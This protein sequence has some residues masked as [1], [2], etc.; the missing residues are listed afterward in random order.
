MATQRQIDQL[1]ATADLVG[2]V[3]GAIAAMERNLGQVEDEAARLRSAIVTARSMLS[4]AQVVRDA[5]AAA[6]KAD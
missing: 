5:A 4:R 1:S 6:C 2:E 3:R